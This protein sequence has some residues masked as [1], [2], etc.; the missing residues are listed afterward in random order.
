MRQTRSLSQTKSY[1]ADGLGIPPERLAA[2]FRPAAISDMPR[3]VAL[4]KGVLGKALTW[5]D[6]SYC[7][8][9]YARFP[10][11]PANEIPYW[12]FEKED[13]LIGGMGLQHVQIDLHGKRHPAVWSCDIMVRPD[14]DGRGLG[15]LMNLFFQETFPFLLVLGTNARSTGMLSRLFHRLPSL[16]CYK[17]LIRTGPFLAHRF[18]S[19]RV[20]EICAFALDPLLSLYDRVHRVEIPQAFTFA[21]IQRGDARLDSLAEQAGREPVIRVH[22]SAAYLAWR[23]FDNPRCHYECHGAFAGDVLR[24]WVVTR[25][26]QNGKAGTIVD[27]L[28]DTRVAEEDLHAILFQWAVERLAGQGAGG[29][30]TYAY[31]AVA[32]SALSKV[33]FVR[34]AAADSPF[35]VGSSPRDI[36]TAVLSAQEWVLTQGDSDIG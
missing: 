31:D 25:I 32:E 33:R 27:W 4:R 16:R 1:L 21:P 7:H 24:G 2:C 19:H 14:Y 35:F 30:Y 36:E 23:F 10:S 22:R 15:V 26:N 12:V 6:V 8:W 5:D 28:C 20:G 11:A 17:K 13:E 3:I 29:V 34:D 9:K 18:G